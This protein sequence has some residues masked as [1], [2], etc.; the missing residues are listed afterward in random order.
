MCNFG[1]HVLLHIFVINFAMSMTQMDHYIKYY[2]Q[3]SIM[4]SQKTIF[5]NK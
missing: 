3:F 5:Y 4:I 2:T 1:K